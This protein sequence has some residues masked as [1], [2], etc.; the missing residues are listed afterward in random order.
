MKQKTKN[1]Y[2][3]KFYNDEYEIELPSYHDGVKKKFLI[4][5]DIHYHEHA[6]KDVFEILFVNAK[7]I[8]PDFIIMPG[9]VIETVT[10]LN[11]PS[12]KEYFENMLKALASIA[13][14]IISP[15]NHEVANYNTNIDRSSTPKTIEYFESLNQYPNIHFLNNKQVVIDSITFTGF[16]PSINYYYNYN[17]EQSG[18]IAYEEYANTYLKMKEE[19]FNVLVSHV[20]PLDFVDKDKTD[21]TIAGHW[22]DGL[23]PK[24]LD[25]FFEDTDKGIFFENFP[26]KKSSYVQYARGVKEF[27]RGYAV[28]TQGYRKHTAD[29]SLFNMLERI[30]S[31]DVETITIQEGITHVKKIR[32]H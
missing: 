6:P 23:I 7:E 15:G 30:M 27:G 26:K 16:S 5:G 21:L 12:E 11:I 3:R 29:I 32:K 18:K 13:P 24:I 25:R 2:R 22:H 28:V 31:N 10:F 9:D 4:V 1:I 8:N 19:D 20:V 17:D 14:L